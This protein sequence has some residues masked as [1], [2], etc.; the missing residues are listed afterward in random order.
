MNKTNEEVQAGVVRYWERKAKEHGMTVDEYHEYRK[1]QVEIRQK[2]WAQGMWDA[3]TFEDADDLLF[4]S[5]RMA[6]TANDGF[7]VD[8]IIKFHGYYQLITAVLDRIEENRD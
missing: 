6:A 3:M 2:K 1:E 8:D 4:Y 7:T 5:E